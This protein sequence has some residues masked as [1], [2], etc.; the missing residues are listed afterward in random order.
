[1][2]SVSGKSYSVNERTQLKWWK[3][4]IGRILA[5]MVDKL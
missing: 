1:M 2:L 5:A 3:C 4:C